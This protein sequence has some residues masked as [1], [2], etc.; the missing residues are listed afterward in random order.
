MLIITMATNNTNNTKLKRAF[1]IIGIS[2]LI[3]GVIVSIVFGIKAIIKNTE[4]GD[5]IIVVTNGP[6]VNGPIVKKLPTDI[7]P[8]SNN[9]KLFLP[10]DASGNDSTGASALDERNKGSHTIRDFSDYENKPFFYVDNDEL[11]LKA[12]AAG[13]TTTGSNYPRSELRQLVG[14]TGKD[15]YWP[16]DKLQKLRVNLRLTEVLNI[17]SDITVTQIKGHSDQPLAI[18]YRKGTGI[19]VEY[20][21]SDRNIDKI[22]KSVRKG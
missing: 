20:N 9:W 19:Y 13:A 11:V 17:K 7:I 14:G 10:V 2:C 21:E 5:N 3:V 8:L 4:D 1:Y 12:H 15:Y 18:R 22:S 16:I 6:I